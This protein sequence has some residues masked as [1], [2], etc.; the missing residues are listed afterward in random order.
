MYT[1]SN[2]LIRGAKIK[3]NYVVIDLGSNTIRLSVF[4]YED[5]KIKTI[6]SQKE[7]AG[8]AGYIKGKRMEPEG[9]KKAC[10][11]LCELKK[12]AVCFVQESDIHVF[13]AA[14]LR[15]ILNQDEV[16]DTIQHITGLLPV[17]LSGEE[18]ARLDFTG[19]SYFTEC[20]DGILID[21]GGASTE[22]VRFRD[23]QPVDLVSMPIGCL[24]IYSKFVG[25]MM[26]N[27][28]ERKKI[29]KEIR[30]QFNAIG[31]GAEESFPLMIGIGGTVRA[32]R[33]LSCELFSAPIDQNEISAQF[34]KKLL[35]KLKN[36]ENDIFHT[37]YKTIPERALTIF[38]GLM[39][40]SEAIKRFES[41]SIFVSAYGVREGF[42]IDRIMNLSATETAE[43]SIL[44]DG[45][46]GSAGGK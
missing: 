33:K 32:A 5:N 19:A 3:M 7:V 22:L 35:R 9:I 20:K 46:P 37:I 41:N 31:W 23:A 28:K 16:L 36:K 13:A 18:E 45:D 42:L 29:K 43:G 11:V 24:S 8:L 26:P 6:L 10:D 12:T 2:M 14:S 40:L 4:C 30:E 34:V 21:I 1:R 27:G 38:T 44:K 17:V 39:I 15:G 25:K